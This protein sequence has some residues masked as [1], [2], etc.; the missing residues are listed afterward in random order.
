MIKEA[1][2]QRRRT[3][4]DLWHDL[5][6]WVLLTFFVAG[7]LAYIVARHYHITPP[8]VLFFVVFLGC[9]AA[10]WVLMFFRKDPPRPEFQGDR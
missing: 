8:P 5:L 3:L 2:V 4:M 9:L 7:S 6:R 1:S 10:N